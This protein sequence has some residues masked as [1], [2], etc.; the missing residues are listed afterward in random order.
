M[1]AID[2]LIGGFVLLG[3][4]QGYRAGL[5][6]ALVGMFGWLIALMAATVLARP[7]APWVADWLSIDTPW[8]AWVAS[9]VVLALAVVVG[10]HIVLW[11][12]RRT[13]QG[14]RLGFL[15]RLAGA[16]FGAARNLLVVLV[17]LST[18]VPLTVDAKIWQDSRSVPVLLPLAPFGMAVSRQLAQ[19]VQTGGRYGMATL[20]DTVDRHAKTP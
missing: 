18:L 1:T 17:V 9:F 4:W 14:L 15:D 11:L 6:R 16:G 20:Q 7:F 2:A 13:L 5:L 10:L 3:L 19:Q 12:L 8:L